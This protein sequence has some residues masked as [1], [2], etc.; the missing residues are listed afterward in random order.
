[1]H[2]RRAGRTASAKGDQRFYFVVQY[3]A[4][5]AV[6]G[7]YHVAVRDR[8]RIRIRLVQQILYHVPVS[9]L[10]S[11]PSLMLIIRNPRARTLIHGTA[12][13]VPR[14]DVTAPAAN[15]ENSLIL[16]PLDRRSACCNP[17]ARL[18]YLPY[19]HLGK[20]QTRIMDGRHPLPTCKEPAMRSTTTTFFSCGN[21][22]GA[23]CM[24]A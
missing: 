7:M 18:Q 4:G 15:E 12:N 5:I 11:Q 14:V 9:A 23:G 22:G 8:C 21:G 10:Y 3:Q 17:V 2:W 1:M 20:G 24:H 6:E 19:R 16:S 13:T